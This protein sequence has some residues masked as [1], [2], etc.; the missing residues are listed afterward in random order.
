MQYPR[1][2]AAADTPGAHSAL[3]SLAATAEDADTRLFAQ[4]VAARETGGQLAWLGLDRARLEALC[5]RRFP[6]LAIAPLHT[7]P[8][9]TAF[10]RALHRHL[11]AHGNPALPADDVDDLARIIAH[12]C[13]RPDHLWKDLGLRGREDVTHALHRYFPGLPERNTGNLRWK[14]FLAY[15]LA[16]AQGLPPSPAPGCPGCEA[17]GECYPRTG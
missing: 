10:T 2:P 8:Q 11:L 5:R 14:K 16:A 17:Y 12:A 13:L 4:L 3:A 1:D 9:E 6:G 15:D 7:C